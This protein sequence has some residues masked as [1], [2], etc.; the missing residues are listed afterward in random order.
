[1]TSLGKFNVSQLPPHEAFFS[2]LKNEN[3]SAEDY[4]LCQTVWEDNDMKTMKEFLTW[5]NNKDVEP[6]FQFNQNCHIDM[7]KDSISVP[8]LT[9]KYMFQDLPDYFT[10]GLHVVVFPYSLAQLVVFGRDIFVFQTTVEGFVRW[11]M[12]DVEFIQRGHP[13]VREEPFLFCTLVGFQVL[14]ITKARGKT[15]ADVDKLQ[16]LCLDTHKIVVPFHGILD[17]VTVHQ[18]S[19]NIYLHGVDVIFPVLKPTTRSSCR[20]CSNCCFNW[21]R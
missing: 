2:T 14:T 4:Q 16:L 5:Y 1:M 8:G 13:L 12:A 17:L 21:Y 6:L 9:L 15:I 20:Y 18:S 3:I 10:H 19:K 11:Q 7:F